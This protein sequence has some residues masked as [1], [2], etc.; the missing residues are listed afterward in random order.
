MYCLIAQWE[1]PYFLNKMHTNVGIFSLSYAV[2]SSF[3]VVVTSSWKGTFSTSTFFEWNYIKDS[4]SVIALYSTITHSTNALT[5]KRVLGR[6]G[7]S[8][9]LWWSQM[10]FIWMHT[11]S[12][13]ITLFVGV[14]R[15]VYKMT[16]VISK[17]CLLTAPAI[18]RGTWV[19]FQVVL[20][21]TLVMN[22]PK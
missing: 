14:W 17:T 12:A 19:Y 2:I 7:W 15:I 11:F 9:W 4:F 16:L 8:K 22:C 1:N 6:D 5:W 3:L 18:S 20:K 10:Q 13:T 21:I